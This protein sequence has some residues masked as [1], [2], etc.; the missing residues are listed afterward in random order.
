MTDKTNN[1]LIERM[2]LRIHGSVGVLQQQPRIWVK[3]SEK[4][5]TR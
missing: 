3:I 2:E 1:G 5:A 4:S